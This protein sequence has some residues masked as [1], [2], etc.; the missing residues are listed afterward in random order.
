MAK[1]K[2]L[3]PSQEDYLEAILELENTKRVARVKYIAEYL[4]VRMPSV[5]GALKQLKSKGLI[6]YEKNSFITL[7][8]EG[9]TAASSV[10]KKHNQLDSFFRE[11][12]LLDEKT[13]ASEACSAEHGISGETIERLSGLSEYLKSDI[14]P[15]IDKKTWRKILDSGRK[16]D[17]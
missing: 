9:K 1:I 16:S 8:K 7:T 15:S 12:L 14:M 17:K 4:D 5:S 11:I 10:F 2:K 13:A 6:D 3:S